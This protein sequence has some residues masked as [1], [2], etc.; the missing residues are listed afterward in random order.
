[1]MRGD[2]AVFGVGAL[3]WQRGK[4]T[5]DFAD[6]PAHRDPEHALPTLHEVD[7][8]VRGGAL[9]NAGAVAHQGDLRQIVDAALAQ[10]LH[11]RANVL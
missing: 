6:D 4:R 5:F 3:T 11:C 1:M 8:F 10:V 2:S 7:H 9:V